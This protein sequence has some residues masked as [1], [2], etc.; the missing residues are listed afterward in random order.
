MK[1]P[2]FFRSE[3]IAV[4]NVD[5]SMELHEGANL[6]SF[7]AVPEDNSLDNMMSSL[8][9]VMIGVIGEGL[10]AN[11]LPNGNW[12]GSLT[13]ISE[14][15]GYWVKIE[16]PGVLSVSDAIPS[17]PSLVYDLHAGANL[18][19][20]PSNISMSVGDAVSDEYYDYILM[21]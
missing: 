21:F 14:T 18:I 7:Y 5:I 20:Y 19:S 4:S 1:C 15:S 12:V 16:G 6:I 11:I 3:T 9:D 17:D 2:I 10:A 13:E 8:D